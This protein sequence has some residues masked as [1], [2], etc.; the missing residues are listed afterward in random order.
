MGPTLIAGF[1]LLLCTALIRVKVY[2]GSGRGI[3]LPATLSEGQIPPPSL[4]LATVLSG[5]LWWGI[6]AG[7]RWI[8]QAV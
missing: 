8:W 1:C 7:M 6:I 4:L 5:C 3:R 2:S